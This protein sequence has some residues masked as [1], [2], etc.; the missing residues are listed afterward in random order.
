MRGTKFPAFTAW[1]VHGLD[2]YAVAYTLAYLRFM[3]TYTQRSTLPLLLDVDTY[4]S[5]LSTTLHSTLIS[6]S[7]IMSQ[8]RI[9]SFF[10]AV[11]DE[12]YAAQVQRARDEHAAA[13]E[14]QLCQDA[15]SRARHVRQ[16][17]AGEPRGVGRPRKRIAA[18]IS[19]SNSSSCASTRATSSS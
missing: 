7:F 18:S 16:R 15:A 3:I 11:A 14:Q 5:H 6:L 12:A 9:G 1:W 4:L 8:S 19:I 2:A 17:E 13:R 10:S